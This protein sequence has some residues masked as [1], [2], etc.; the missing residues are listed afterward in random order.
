MLDSVVISITL[1]STPV[2]VR[3]ISICDCNSPVLV[4]NS[5]QHVSI[6]KF[7]IA[8]SP[9][10]PKRTS[11]TCD[12]NS[13]VLVLNAAQHSSSCDCNSPVLVRKSSQHDSRISNELIISG[14]GIGVLSQHSTFVQ[15]Q[16]QL[17][18]HPRRLAKQQGFER[19]QQEIIN[20][21]PF[22]IQPICDCS[23]PVLVLS[24]A[25]Q[26]SCS[27]SNSFMLQCTSSK[28]SSRSSV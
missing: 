26:I 1:I 21:L 9:N 23:S 28:Q 24:S 10:N 2:K 11:S 18:G 3:K 12:S 7:S 19:G 27:H 16:I 5:A 14:S 8:N 15:Q 13:P 6:S 17:Q 20:F 4:F 25:Q 22:C